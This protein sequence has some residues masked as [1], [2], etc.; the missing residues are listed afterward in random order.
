MQGNERYTVKL[1]SSCVYKP[2][3]LEHLYDPESEFFCCGQCPETKL[4]KPVG[5]SFP[6]EREA[7]RQRWLQ[8]L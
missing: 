3:D 4:H 8:L 5:V 2:E 7:E 1:C 6:R